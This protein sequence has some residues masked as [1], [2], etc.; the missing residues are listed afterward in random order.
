MRFFATDILFRHAREL[1]QLISMLMFYNA[2]I[3]TNAAGQIILKNKDAYAT[4]II[5][6]SD[7]DVI[8]FITKRGNQEI[9]IS[10]LSMSWQVI[11]LNCRAS[12]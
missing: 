8:S 12:S 6:I 5:D 2:T 1:V 9:L 4:S 7:E 10:R 11:P 3:F